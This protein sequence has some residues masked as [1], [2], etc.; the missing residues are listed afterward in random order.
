MND[1]SFIK[2]SQIV[3]ASLLVSFCVFLSNGFP[4]SVYASS[5]IKQKSPSL[6][7]YQYIGLADAIKTFNDPKSAIVDARPAMFYKIRHIERAINISA[8]ELNANSPV[9]KS[10]I[11][12]L[13]QA[14]AVMVYCSSSCGAAA[15]VAT[16][17]TKAGVAN[18]MIYGEGWLEWNACHLPS[19]GGEKEAH[20]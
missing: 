4:V 19:V 13:K 8:A 5:N 20:K 10:N 6:L 7:P 17:L 12:S 3:G 15:E 9:F 11:S 2:L 14:N 18:V 16:V 1:L